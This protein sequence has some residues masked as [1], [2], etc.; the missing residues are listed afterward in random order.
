M[1]IQVKSRDIECLDERL[2]IVNRV[3]DAV[4]IKILGCIA[5]TTTELIIKY[6]GSIRNL[7]DQWI[8]IS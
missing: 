7:I 3:G 6:D 5:L 1:A 2:K 4:E 8:Q